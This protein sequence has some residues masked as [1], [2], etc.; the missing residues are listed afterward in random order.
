MTTAFLMLNENLEYL[1]R[2]AFE[3]SLTIN[4][5]AAGH[6]PVD[7]YFDADDSDDNWVSRE[8]REEAYRSGHFVK[9]QLYP[10]G[11]VTFFTLYGTQIEDVVACLVDIC[12]K[13]QARF[14]G[15]GMD[16]KGSSAFEPRELKP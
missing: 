15:N 8:Q 16:P 3:F 13:E 1:Q 14:R 9:G 11:S 2:E 10:N 4:P 5:H 12:R 7:E 6:E